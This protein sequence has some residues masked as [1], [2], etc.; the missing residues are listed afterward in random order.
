MGCNNFNFNSSTCTQVNTGFWYS[1]VMKYTDDSSNAIDLTGFS[2]SMTIKDALGG[3]TLLTLSSGV[4]DSTTGFHIPDPTA[5]TIYMQITSIDSDMTG[6]NYPY[7]I[8]ITDSSG[9]DQI[10]MQ[11]YI[12][13]VDRGL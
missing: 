6:G 7:E 4:D 5:G 2:L 13:F 12:N 1:R 10:F 11:G 9:K 8:V 3:S